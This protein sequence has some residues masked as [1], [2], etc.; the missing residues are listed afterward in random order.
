MRDNTTILLVVSWALTGFA[1]GA[2]AALVHPAPNEVARMV[3]G[4]EGSP[5]GRFIEGAATDISGNFYTA[6]YGGDQSKNSLA[7]V[8]PNGTAHLIYRDRDP[9]T[10]LNSVR[11]IRPPP[12]YKPHH[13]RLLTGDVKGHRVLQLDYTTRT[14]DNLVPHSP[15]VSVRCADPGMLQP[16]DIAVTSDGHVYL[17]GMNYTQDSTL[18]DGDLWW[19][20][21]EG[22]AR[23][24]DVMYRTN[25][26]EVSPEN[27]YLYLSEANNRNGSVVT[28]RIWRY[29]IDSFTGVKLRNQRPIRSLFVDFEK[30]D[31]TQAY[32][33]DGIRCDSQGN[34]FVT[35]NG[36]GQVAVFDLKGV[37]KFRIH[38]PAI[39]GVTNLEFSGR[40]GRVLH[41]VG[42][43][44]D[45]A[46]AT[47]GCIARWTHDST[48]LEWELLH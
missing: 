37:L 5:F 44:Q 11:S 40:D 31:Q 47:K 35:R 3:V 26:I 38:L 15:V 7:M 13:L 8:T 6:N 32:D 19:C 36:L 39:Q 28:N 48:G 23:R 9:N 41:I 43:C 34:L 18:G 22:K 21:P 25:G 20:S 1:L 46:N 10:W 24:L 29:H 4:P 45:K 27:R 30:L 42:S 2:N 14:A 16:N 33:V 17:S 12:G